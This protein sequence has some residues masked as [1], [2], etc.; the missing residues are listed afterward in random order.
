MSLKIPHN[1]RYTVMGSGSWAT[2]ITKILTHNLDQVGWYVREPAMADAIADTGHNPQFSS[3]IEFDPRKLKL[4]LSVNDAVK[5]SDVLIV[6][7]PSAYIDVWMEGLTE[8]LSNKFIVSAVKG[9][10]PQSNQTIL[11]YMHKQFGVDESQMGFV[12]GPCHAEEIALERLSFLTFSCQDE[13]N[14]KAIAQVFACPF[15]HTIT[16]TDVQGTEYAS[17]LKNIYA[18]A[19][20]VCHGLGYG[21]NFL[22]VL[23]SNAH[24]ELSRFLQQMFPAHREVNHSAYLGDLLV[25]C[26]SQFSRNRT[27]GT[28]VGKGYRVKDAQL[29]MNMVAEGYYATQCMHVLN[30]NYQVHLPIAETMYRILYE[31]A[32][33]KNEILAL[34]EQLH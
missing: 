9:I 27:L 22:A 31:N 13:A 10:I 30:K 16:G 28:M 29:E 24:V 6:V 25:T 26:Y 23:V 32:D 5:E 8:S 3:S 2:A 18:V 15:V 20:G 21:D 1:A 11:G 4:Y 14:S 34:T 33:A 12:T 7:I 17:I 19:A